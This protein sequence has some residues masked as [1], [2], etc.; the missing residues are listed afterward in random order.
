[1]KLFGHFVVSVAVTIAL[2][3]CVA[4]VDEP[5]PEAPPAARVVTAWDPLEC[6]GSHR[7]AVEL[8]DGDGALVSG[9]VPCARGSVALDVPHFGV[10]RGRVYAWELDEPIRSVVP[11]Q[12]VVDETIVRWLVMT[13][14]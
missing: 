6:G 11:V 8:E 5:F 14:R 13:P 10:Y 2:W 4:C 12:L 7:V 1:M 3:V 9:S